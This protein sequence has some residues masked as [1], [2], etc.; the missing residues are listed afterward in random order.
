MKHAGSEALDTLVPVLAQL[1]NIAGLKEK[2]AAVS[3]ADRAPS[4]IFMKIPPDSLL[5]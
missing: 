5:I 3:I 2:S 4:C 1:S